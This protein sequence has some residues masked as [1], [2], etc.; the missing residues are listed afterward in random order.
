MPAPGPSM[1]FPMEPTPAPAADTVSGSLAV[2]VDRLQ[3]FR[4]GR[5]R[6]VRAHGYEIA[7]FNVDGEFFAIDNACPH[8]GAA[9]VDGRVIGTNVVCPWHAWHVDLRTGTCWHAPYRPSATYTVEVRD[10]TVWVVVPEPAVPAAPQ[11]VDVIFRRP[12]L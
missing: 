11:P 2:Q 3:D 6:L 10:D 8:H 4:P 12:L 5:S 7:V 1:S 9:M